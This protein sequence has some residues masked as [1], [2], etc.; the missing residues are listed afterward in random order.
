MRPQVP[1]VILGKSANTLKD[2]EKFLR[3]SGP[4]PVRTTIR[5]PSN[6]IREFGKTP[7]S[8][9]VAQ[10]HSPRTGSL[11]PVRG[12]YAKNLLLLREGEGDPVHGVDHLLHG[13]TRH[14]IHI[15]GEEHAIPAALRHRLDEGVLDLGEGSTVRNGI[16]VLDDLRG[17]GEEVGVVAG[18]DV[19]VNHHAAV[20]VRLLRSSVPGEVGH[21]DTVVAVIAV[22]VLAL[23][24]AHAEAHEGLIV[25][26]MTAH[27]HP[28]APG[29]QLGAEAV[30][31][32]ADDHVAD[33]ESGGV[34]R[35]DAL[36]RAKHLVDHR[37]R[38]VGAVAVEVGSLC[39][40]DGDS[41]GRTV[42]DHHE[43][44][45]LNVVLRD[46]I[47]H[48]FGGNGEGFHGRSA[49]QREE[50]GAGEVGRNERPVE[51]GEQLLPL[52]RIVLR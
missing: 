4:R 10:R 46:P 43:G 26:P 42:R 35:M 36:H 7:N 18:E 19:R 40:L 41:V 23:L 33:A 47:L 29:V 44:R 13:L 6:K 2:F 50:V 5:R 37:D 20:L 49:V 15:P 27:I 48:V 22:E 25:H 51:H 34:H 17:L 30:E 28:D 39:V 8:L 11:L 9:I 24:V 21:F 52:L 12:N 14:D 38:A 3:G 16:L 32:G 45:D 31:H 1:E